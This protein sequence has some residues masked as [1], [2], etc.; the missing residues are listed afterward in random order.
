MTQLDCGRYTVSAGQACQTA[1]GVLYR[2][3]KHVRLQQVYCIGWSSMSDCGRYTVSAGQACQ[4]AA[5]VLYRLVKHVRLQQVYCI[6]WSSMSDCSRCTVSAGQACQTALRS[7]CVAVTHPPERLK[8]IN[9]LIHEP[10][11]PYG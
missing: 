10:F 3:V 5:G 9:A 7:V 1:A 8:R 6:G 11:R 4:T 2:L